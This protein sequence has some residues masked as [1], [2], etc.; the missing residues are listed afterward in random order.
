MF[1][2]RGGI[3]IKNKTKTEYNTGFFEKSIEDVLKE[4][5]KFIKYISCPTV[6]EQLICVGIDGLTIKYIS[7]PC[8]EVQKKAILNNIEAIKYINNPDVNIQRMIMDMDI[9]YLADIDVV[10]DELQLEIINSNP[11]N[12][13]VLRKPSKYVQEIIITKHSLYI[14]YLNFIDEVLELSLIKK[15]PEYINII[16]HPSKSSILYLFD[17]GIQNIIKKPLS[18]SDEVQDFIVKK[19]PEACIYFKYPNKKSREILLCNAMMSIRDVRNPS[20]LELLYAFIGKHFKS[21][22][23]F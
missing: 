18:C 22:D 11:K 2:F 16:K 4:K 14:S 3:H 5:H 19:H 8:F 1:Y 23:L 17:K 15:E 10:D 7:N 20:N 9:N 13:Y 12:I 6:R 21:I